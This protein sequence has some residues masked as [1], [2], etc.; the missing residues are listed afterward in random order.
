MPQ[1]TDTARLD[2][3]QDSGRTLYRVVETE[4]VPLTTPDPPHYE[5]R[6]K[7]L[8]W[9]VDTRFDEELDIRKAIDAGMDN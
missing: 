2:W 4:R 8:G 6:E 9:S 3:L 5:E 7:F 1:R